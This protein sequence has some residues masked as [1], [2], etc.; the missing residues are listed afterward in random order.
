[1]IFIAAGNF[2]T[3]TF[4]TILLFIVS[5]MPLFVIDGQSRLYFLRRLVSFNTCKKLLQMFYQPV[6]ASVIF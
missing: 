4:R 5:M 1:M 6:A 3:S 2:N